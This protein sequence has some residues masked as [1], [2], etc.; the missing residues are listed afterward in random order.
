MYFL[1]APLC[2]LAVAGLQAL[3]AAWPQGKKWAYG[4]TGSGLGATL[5]AMAGLHPH[6]YDYFNWLVDRATPERL[7]AQYELDYWGIASWEALDTLRAR[8]PGSFYMNDAPYGEIGKNRQLLP[9][10]DQQR[11]ALD[12]LRADFYIHYAWPRA[13]AHPVYAPSFT[14]RVYGNTLFDVA[15]LNLS[16]VDEAT[17]EPYRAHYRAATAR[18]PVAQSRFDVYLDEQAV[19][20]V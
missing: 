9:A 4:L 19:T 15:A 8:Y 13:N 6:Q 20:Y 3:L 11:I 17:A 18:P 10:A 5:V 1:Y 2:L 12:N 16:L 7:G 14:R